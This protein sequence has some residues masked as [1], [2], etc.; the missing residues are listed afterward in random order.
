MVGDHIEEDPESG[1]NSVQE[2]SVATLQDVLKV[3]AEQGKAIGELTYAVK[4]R[5]L[6]KVGSW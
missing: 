6:Q 1:D 3:L 4:G 2:G 5:V